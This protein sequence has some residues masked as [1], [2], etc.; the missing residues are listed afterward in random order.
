[1]LFPVARYRPLP[2]IANPM[3]PQH[4]HTCAGIPEKKVALND[5]DARLAALEQELLAA[6]SSGGSMGSWD[7]GEEEVRVVIGHAGFD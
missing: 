3:S 5:L 4:I 6:D 1:M 7:G 2:R